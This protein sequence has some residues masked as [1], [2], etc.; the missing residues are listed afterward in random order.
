MAELGI[1]LMRQNLRR[2]DP[3]ASDTEI[4]AALRRWL[5]G[6]PMD[7]DAPEGPSSSP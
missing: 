2:R 7:A 5:T 6:R 4:D 1:G 3:R